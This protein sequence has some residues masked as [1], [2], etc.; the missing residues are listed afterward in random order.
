MKTLRYA[1]AAALLV[2]A[3]AVP[4]MAEGPP[5]V[6]ADTGD[7]AWVLAGTIGDGKIFIV[8]LEECIRI[9]TGET[10]GVAIG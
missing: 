3:A 2:L 10:D 8:P 6:K 5:S 7:T 4:A 9:R 1:A